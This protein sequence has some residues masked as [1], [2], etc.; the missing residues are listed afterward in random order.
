MQRIAEVLLG[1]VQPFPLM[2]G[3]ITGMTLVS[4]TMTAIYLS[5]AF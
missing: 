3:K 5:G 4:L 1:S 2:M